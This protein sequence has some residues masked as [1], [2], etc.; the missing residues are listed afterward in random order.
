M[1]DLQ[2]KPPVFSQHEQQHTIL[3]DLNVC[4]HYF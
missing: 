3:E 4:T 1:S 2:R